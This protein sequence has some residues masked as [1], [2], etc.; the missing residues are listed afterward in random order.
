MGQRELVGAIELLDVPDQGVEVVRLRFVVA[1]QVEQRRE[2]FGLA[3]DL[4][5]HK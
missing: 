2:R 5:R 3:F 4:R 1:A